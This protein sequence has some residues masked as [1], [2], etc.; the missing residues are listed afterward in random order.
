MYLQV[1]L[2]VTS[3]KKDLLL[4]DFFSRKFVLSVHK[5]IRESIS[6]ARN[7]F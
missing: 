1:N 3:S 4:L 5:I 2:V 7:N 6:I